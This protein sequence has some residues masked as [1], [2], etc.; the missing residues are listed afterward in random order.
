MIHRVKVE[1]YVLRE[2]KLFCTKRICIRCDGKAAN[3]DDWEPITAWIP[4][5]LLKSAADEVQTSDQSP[6]CG[7]PATLMPSF[8]ALAYT[9]S[10]EYSRDRPEWLRES[11]KID[12][13]E[14]HLNECRQLYNQL[15]NKIR[16][17]RLVLQAGELD[18]YKLKETDALQCLMDKQKLEKNLDAA[19][20]LRRKSMRLNPDDVLAELAEHAEEEAGEALLKRIDPYHDEQTR[21]EIKLVSYRIGGRSKGKGKGK[22]KGKSKKKWDFDQLKR[23]VDKLQGRSEFEPGVTIE[24]GDR[25]QWIP[26]VQSG[27]TS[28]QPATAVVVKVDA[29]GAIPLTLQ[30]LRGTNVDPPTRTTEVRRSRDCRSC[31][32]KIPDTSDTGPYLCPCWTAWKPLAKSAAPTKWSAEPFVLPKS[33]EPPD[34]ISVGVPE[35]DSPR[36]QWGR[37]AY[38]HLTPV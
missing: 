8:T 28:L 38:T 24:A 11:S 19:E 25:I 4:H 26:L 2:G 23:E 13:A 32:G 37:S 17:E 18:D 34:S 6:R 5:F 30:M 14:I 1:F 9:C 20:A 29:G 15:C 36:K 22:G 3:S 12:E 10:L 31:R 35:E 33:G 21:E 7:D 27:H 16:D